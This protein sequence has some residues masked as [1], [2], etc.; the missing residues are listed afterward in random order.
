MPMYFPP[1]VMVADAHILDFFPIAAHLYGHC[2]C[3][4]TVGGSYYAAVLIGL[5][6][7]GIMLFYHTMVIAIQFLIPLYRTEI[8]GLQKCGGHCSVLSFL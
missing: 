8:G 1:I 2:Q 7:I 6:L 3:L 4:Q 5:L